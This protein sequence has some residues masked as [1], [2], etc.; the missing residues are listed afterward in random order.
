ML[1]SEVD[2]EI[3]EFR[4]GAGV[5]A[6]RVYSTAPGVNFNELN[7]QTVHGQHTA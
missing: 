6:L 2:V 7:L 3:D 1:V 4:H 5:R